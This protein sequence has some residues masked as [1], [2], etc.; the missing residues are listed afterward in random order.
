MAAVGEGVGRYV[1]DAHDDGALAEREGPGADIPIEAWARS[2]GHEGILAG[3]R[4]SADRA[5][6]D[7]PP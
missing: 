5:S 3:A 7:G 2:K 1:E 4:L 6:H